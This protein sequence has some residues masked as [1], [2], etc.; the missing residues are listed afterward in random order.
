MKETI[1]KLSSDLLQKDPYTTDPIELQRVM[2]KDFSHN[3]L[4]K[5][6]IKH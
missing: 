2:H 3:L 4:V 6:I 5:S 1:G